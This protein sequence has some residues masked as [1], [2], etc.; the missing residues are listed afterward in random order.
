M[1]SVGA[2]NEG[3]AD[4]YF[5]EDQKKLVPEGI[6]GMV[7]HKGPLGDLVFQMVG[8]LR[9]GMGYTGSATIDELHKRAQ[10]HPDHRG[11]PGGEPPARRDHHQRSAQLR[12]AVALLVGARLRARGIVPVE[13]Q[14][15]RHH[16]LDLGSGPV[17]QFEVLDLGQRVLAQRTQRRH[18]PVLR[19]KQE[20]FGR[21]DA[22]FAYDATQGPGRTRRRALRCRTARIATPPGRSPAAPAA[23]TEWRARRPRRSPHPPLRPDGPPRAPAD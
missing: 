15:L 20:T 9:A 19:A 23:S 8:G 6:E 11:R 7:P 21:L 1:G 12:A 17:V 14:R 18:R 22:G 4:R 2:M 16:L 3:S 5:Q 10:V 13:C